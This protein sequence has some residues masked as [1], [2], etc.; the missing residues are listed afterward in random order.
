MENLPFNIDENSN[1]VISI[2]GSGLLAKLWVSYFYVAAF[3]LKYLTKMQKYAVEAKSNIQRKLKELASFELIAQDLIPKM[4]LN[5][6]FYII[7]LRLAWKIVVVQECAPENP[8][9]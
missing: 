8:R 7:I 9:N 3:E 6:T 2:V 1:K 5:L 4:D